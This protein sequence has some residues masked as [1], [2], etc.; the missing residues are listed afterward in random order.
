MSSFSTIIVSCITS[1]L[2]LSWLAFRPCLYTAIK[3]NIVDHPNKRKLQDHPIPV[4]GGVA[5]AIG[6]FVPMLF[7]YFCYGFTSTKLLLS[8]LGMNGQKVIIWSPTNNMGKVG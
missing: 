3:H 1:T 2:L 4:L 8:N 7:T 5:V 6:I